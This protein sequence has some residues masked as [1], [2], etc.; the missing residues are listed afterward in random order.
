VPETPTQ[1]DAEAAREALLEVVQDFPFAGPEHRSAWLAGLLTLFARPAI[2]GCVPM[3]AID[4]TTAGTGKSRMADTIAVLATGRA[5]P[6]T[7]YSRE[8]EEFRKRV[9]SQCIEGETIMLLDNVQCVLKSATLEAFITSETWQD[10]RLGVSETVRAPNVTVTMVTANNLQVAGDLVRRTLH[11]RLESQLDRPDLRDDLHHPD[12]LGWVASNRRRLVPA[13]LTILRAHALAG[14][15]MCGLRELGGFEA[16]SRIVAAA[17]VWCGAGNP[18]AAR[19]GLLA[20][21]DTER[22]SLVAMLLGLAR[23]CPATGLTAKEILGYLY[24]EGK[25]PQ[26]PDGYEDLRDALEECAT[27]AGKACPTAKRLGAALRSYRGRVIG[28]R[29]IE[30]VDGGNAN[31]LRWR[32][33]ALHVNGSASAVTPPAPTRYEPA[34]EQPGAF[35]GL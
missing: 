12:L 16:W 29:M 34:E 35:D 2:A 18:L 3:I 10:I 23:L 32:V 22:S 8:E 11:I 20:S 1:R 26:T 17:V 5:A 33:K 6:R 13:A 27:P 21:S 7:V 15:P 9:T 24:H 31:V 14:R 19:E 4:A 28:G 30:S 25:A